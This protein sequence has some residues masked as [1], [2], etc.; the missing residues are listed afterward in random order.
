MSSFNL[1]YRQT[2]RAIIKLHK[3]G[4][5]G[6]RELDKNGKCAYCG[7]NWFGEQLAEECTYCWNGHVEIPSVVSGMRPK[8]QLCSR[9]KGSGFITI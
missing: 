1:S 2:K 6:A 4:G 8:R 9:C 5:C 3:C 7:N